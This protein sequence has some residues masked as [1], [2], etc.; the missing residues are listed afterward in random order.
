MKIDGDNPHFDVLLKKA[1][2]LTKH[3]RTIASAIA[4]IRTVVFKAKVA[5]PTWSQDAEEWPAWAAAL[6]ASLSSMQQQNDRNAEAVLQAQ[7]VPDNGGAEKVEAA[8]ILVGA[9]IANSVAM[10]AVCRNLIKTADAELLKA[11]WFALAFASTPCKL[12]TSRKRPERKALR[13]LQLFLRQKL[14]APMSA[15]CMR[16]LA[17]EAQ[18]CYFLLRFVSDR[19]LSSIWRAVGCRA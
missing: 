10:M 5:N 2:T 11:C 7:H 9:E 4:N 1:A 6:P 18:S 15:S 19:P 14:I 8:T 13:K 12:R 3:V 16:P 17:S